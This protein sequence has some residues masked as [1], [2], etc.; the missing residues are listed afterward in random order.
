MPLLAAKKSTAN[1][2]QHYAVCLY[3]QCT[4]HLKRAS[5]LL[6]FELLESYIILKV[7]SFKRASTCSF[8]MQSS[9]HF[10]LQQM[11]QKVVCKHVP[12]MYSNEEIQCIMG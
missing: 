2:V 9:M 10:Q 4:F 11:F 12:K 8:T 3:E 6:C 1:F 5:I 7:Q